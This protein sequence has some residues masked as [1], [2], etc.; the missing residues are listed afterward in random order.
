MPHPSL[1]KLLKTHSNSVKYVLILVLGLFFFA[2]LFFAFSYFTVKNIVVEKGPGKY[3]I[4]GID[5]LKEKNLLLL[6]LP[7]EENNLEE[8]NPLVEFIE[9]KKQYPHTLRIQIYD[10][11][12]IATLKLTNGYALLNKE[13]K[14]LSKAKEADSKFTLITY[15]QAFDYTMFQSGEKLN[16]SEIITALFFL[17]K[18]SRLN[19][20]VERI[21][22]SGS[23]VIVC[24]LRDKKIFISNTKD[25]TQQLFELETIIKQ[26]KIKAQNFKELDLRFDKPIVRF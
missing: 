11:R 10:S 1:R 5:N 26:F 3:N 23:S 18:M 2:I 12:P 25:K 24:Y 22:I 13:G 17:E 20:Q 6:S 7:Q 21:D 19:L 15:Y 8:Q 16:Y 14:I 4:I 9:I